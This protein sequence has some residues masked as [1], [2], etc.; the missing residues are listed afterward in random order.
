MRSTSFILPL[1]LLLIAPGA[2]AVSGVSVT[3]HW[4]GEFEN[5]TFY[6]GFGEIWRHDI[7]DDVVV[8][9]QMIYEGPAREPRINFTGTQV[10]LIK[11]DGTIALMS[12]DGGPVTDLILGHPHGTIDWPEGDWIYYNLGTW[13]DQTSRYLRR[14]NAVS[15]DDEEVVEFESSTWRFGIARDHQ[16]A[17]VR[18]TSVQ[19]TIVAYDLVND[20]GQMRSSRAVD[21]PSC[22]TAMDPEGEYFLD[23][24]I[25]HSGVDIRR[26]DD[27]EIVESFTHV[28]AQA[29]GDRDSGE[30]HNRNHWANNAQ[31][32]L[33]M[34]VGWNLHFSNDSRGSNQV[35]YN[36]VEHAR[37]V[38]TENDDYSYTYD[39]AG[40]FWVDYNVINEPPTVSAGEDF[41]VVVDSPALLLGNASDD[42][43]IRAPLAMAW[44][45]DS[46]PGTAT[47]SAP[48]DQ[49]SLVSLDQPGTYG[50]RLTAS[51]GEHVV[52]DAVE[53]LA[54]DQPVIDLREP[55]GGENWLAG[56]VHDIVWD[57]SGVDDVT[58]AYSID[59]GETWSVVAPTVDTGS[60]EWGRYAWTVPPT[61]SDRC[62]VALWAYVDGSGRSMS[63]RFEIHTSAG[64]L[65]IQ[66]PAAG[67]VFVVGTDEQ[68]LW[69]SEEL[70]AVVLSYSSDDG[71]TWHPIEFVERSQPAWGDFTWR[72]PDAP[73]AKT[74]V[75]VADMADTYR[76]V[77][78]GR[79]EIRA[80]PAAEGCTCLAA[81]GRGVG[82]T[83]LLLSL[84][85]LLRRRR[86]LR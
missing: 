33:A 77:V 19:N 85:A 83:A 13:G 84:L 36:W 81:D 50:L 48:F 32:W 26:W 2:V 60:P 69:A 1:A 39:S 27:L 16:R 12:I 21:V 73:S 67:D 72:V 20:N 38:V 22:G 9:H 68:I 70:D 44:S 5:A 11:E 82:A 61:P 49:R 29:W 37:I 62:R 10:A 45:Q 65:A 52:S 71:L 8:S 43:R 58:I 74:R 64:D 56:E 6:G 4:S 7:R 51:D 75:A 42:G 25:D 18:D 40:D 80:A 79:F 31:D 28:A 30:G 47:F 54:T 35:L 57:A 53:V 59:D 23:G 14:V 78:S 63:E 34:H 55:A 76:R 66:R 24:M 17:A 3:A 15:G 86:G 41:V 46:G